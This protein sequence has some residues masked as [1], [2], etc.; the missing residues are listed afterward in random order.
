MSNEPTKNQWLA[1]VVFIGLAVWIGHSLPPMSNNATTP[2]PPSTIAPTTINKT[3]VHTQS[4]SNSTAKT[5]E[6]AAFTPQPDSAIPDDGFGK[7][8]KLGQEIFYNTPEKAVGF[9]GNDLKCSNCHLDKGRQPNS[10]PLWAAYVAYPAFRSKNGHVNSFQ[11]RLQGCFRYSMNGKAPDLDSQTLIAL[12]SYAY[13]LAKGLPTGD[14]KVAGR[15]YPQMKAPDSFDFDNGEKVFAANCAV[16]HGSDGL[17]QK[18]ANGA[19]VFPP[20]WGP[21]SFNWGAG[22]G[23]INNAAGF[24]KANMPYSRGNTLSDK[25][26]W[27]VAAFMDS[28]ERPQDPRFNGSVAETRKKYNDSKM[29]L[30]GTKV[31]DIVLGE[32]SPPSG[33]VN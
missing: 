23:S 8:V 20:L 4:A 5:P 6:D 12:E 10:A 32:N 13:F 3:A 28:H 24:I 1:G 26:A 31:G 22:M 17:G 15:G 18:A 30:Y 9:T 27:D 11:E 21:R 25:D 2:T 33:T 7:M 29:S 14:A 16:C 19:T